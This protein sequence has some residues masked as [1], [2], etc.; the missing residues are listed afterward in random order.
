VSE[1]LL[2]ERTHLNSPRKGSVTVT[3]NWTASN[4]NKS[5]ARASNILVSIVAEPARDGSTSLDMMTKQDV[6]DRKELQ[7]F[8]FERE[9]ELYDRHVNMTNH[10]WC[11]RCSNYCWKAQKIEVDYDE[12]NPEHANDHPDMKGMYV[13]RDGTK[14]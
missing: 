7:L 8:K 6:L 12:A 4:V 11:H 14:P 5:T 2:K 10:A 3:R 1:I 13:R 9:K